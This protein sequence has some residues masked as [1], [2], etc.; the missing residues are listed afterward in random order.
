MLQ[1]LVLQVLLVLMVLLVQ[2]LLVP[3]FS[4]LSLRS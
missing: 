3:L 4:C 2:D 1:V